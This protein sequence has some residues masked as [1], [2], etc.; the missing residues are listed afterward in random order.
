MITDQRKFWAE[1]GMRV[2][3]G[4]LIALVAGI[5]KSV[6]AQPKPYNLVLEDGGVYWQLVVDVENADSIQIANDLIET[7]NS[8]GHIENVEPAKG[9]IRFSIKD[10]IMDVK[11]YGIKKSAPAIYRDGRWSGKGRID[12]KNGRYRVTVKDIVVFYNAG[13]LGFSDII[14]GDINST[15]EKLYLNKKHTAWNFNTVEQSMFLD[16]ALKNLIVSRSEEKKE[17]W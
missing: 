4:L 10:Y 15:A 7:L 12:V 11:K 2:K 13:Q 8:S 3:I 17:D 14:S 16:A 5:S 6:F 1:I 9:Y